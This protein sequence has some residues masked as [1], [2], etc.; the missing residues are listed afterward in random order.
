MSDGELGK[1]GFTNYAS[2]RLEGLGGETVM[3]TFHDLVAVPEVAERQYQSE[4]GKHICMP[5]CIGPLK[6]IGHAEGQRDTEF[7]C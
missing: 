5:A 2:D 3:R 6:Y 4:G 7:F 1:V